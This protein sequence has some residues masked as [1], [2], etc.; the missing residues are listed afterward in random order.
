MWGCQRTRGTGDGTYVAVGP[1]VCRGAA[2]EPVEGDGFQD[3][4]DGGILVGP[5]EELLADP[6]QR[7]EGVAV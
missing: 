7:C 4:V 1:E 2:A 6:G 5:V 3:G